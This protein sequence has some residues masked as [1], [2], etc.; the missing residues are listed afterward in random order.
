MKLIMSYVTAQVYRIHC[1]PQGDSGKLQDFERIFN[2][3][4]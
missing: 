1:I 4:M 3:L 2:I